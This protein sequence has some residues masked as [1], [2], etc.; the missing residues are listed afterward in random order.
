VNDQL[1]C[2]SRIQAT[3]DEDGTITIQCPSKRCGAGNGVLV[4]HK[5]IW[6]TRELVET[7]R[8]Q[9]PDRLFEQRGRSNAWR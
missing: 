6:E 3:I 8:M 2:Q 7:Y 5:Y 4:F 9:S 1:R